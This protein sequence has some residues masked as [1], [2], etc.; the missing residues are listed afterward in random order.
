[1]KS[2]VT[3]GGGFIAGHLIR[4]LLERGDDVRAADLRPLPE[5]KQVHPGA[6]NWEYCDLSEY[7][8]FRRAAYG[9]GMIYHLAADSGGMGYISYHHADCTR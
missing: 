6:D 1:M 4:A 3:G 9:R 2:L 8:N 7:G 5:W